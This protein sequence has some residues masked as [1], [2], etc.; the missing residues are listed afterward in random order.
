M[1]DHR[2]N[3]RMETLYQLVLKFDALYRRCRALEQAWS[4]EPAEHKQQISI[5]LTAALMGVI[6]AYQEIAGL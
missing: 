6:E 2:V 1:R 3:E 4:E 5:N